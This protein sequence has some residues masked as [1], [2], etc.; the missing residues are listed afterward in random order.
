MKKGAIDN[1]LKQSRTLIDKSP[2]EI[3]DMPK[4]PLGSSGDGS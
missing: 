4:R 3:K 1:V 2:W